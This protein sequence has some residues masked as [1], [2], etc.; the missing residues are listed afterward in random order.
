M[1]LI[2][3]ILSRDEWRAAVAEGRTAGSN[4]TVS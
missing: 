4:I 1:R 3:K 2:Y